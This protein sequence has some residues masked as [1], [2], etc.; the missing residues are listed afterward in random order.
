VAAPENLDET[1]CCI[2]HYYAN[3]GANIICVSGSE[4]RTGSFM[5]GY[6][7]LS[8]VNTLHDPDV[9]VLVDANRP[10][11]ES[12]QLLEI[13]R[14]SSDNGCACLARPLINGVART[15]GSLIIEVPEKSQFVEFVTPEGIRSSLLNNQ[16]LSMGPTVPSL[17]DLALKLEVQPRCIGSNERNAK[18]T[19]PEDLHHFEALQRKYS[20][21]PPT[22]MKK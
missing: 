9:V 22:P 5:N 13:V 19:Y 11:V 1:N 17:V 7:Y 2:E 21:E 10:F 12:N 18:L 3:S 20:I 16:L 6:Q 14:A 4:E 15:L 8:D